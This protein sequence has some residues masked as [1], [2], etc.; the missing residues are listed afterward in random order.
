ME[1]KNF[2]F[3]SPDNGENFFITKNKQLNTDNEEIF[4]HCK[5]L[6]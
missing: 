4:L 5:I 3:F 2:N 6:L 1:N